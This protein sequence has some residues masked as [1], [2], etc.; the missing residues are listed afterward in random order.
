MPVSAPAGVAAPEP[1]RGFTGNASA[2]GKK[3]KDET[4]KRYG[5]LSVIE[6]APNDGNLARWRC[7]CD[8]GASCVVAG[9]YLRQGKV[10][11]CPACHVDGRKHQACSICGDPAHRS[12]WCPQRPKDETAVVEGVRCRGCGIERAEETFRTTDYAGG[13]SSLA[14][15]IG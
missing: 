9:A 11:S 4:G 5:K 10:A 1:R 15:A 3:A 12:P 8:C 7:G 13:E 2:W 14:R 6:R